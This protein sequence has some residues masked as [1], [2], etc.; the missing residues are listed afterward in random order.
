MKK[1]LVLLTGFVL[2][3]NVNMANAEE[4]EEIQ[5]K[6]LA[7]LLE[8]VRQGKVVNARINEQ[9]ER[10]FNADK[11]RQNQALSD[12]RRQQRNEEARSERLES[13]FEA[14]EQ[15]IAGLQE[16]L[17]KRLGS[18]RELF[19]VLQQVSG[20]TQGVFSGS[21]ISAQYPGREQWLGEFAQSMG[22]SSKLATI[23]EIERLWTEIQPE[24]T[25]SGK[26]VRFNTEV[27]AVDGQK[28]QREV[29]RIGAWNLVSNGEYV[30]YDIENDIVKELPR[31]PAGRFV[32][33]AASLEGSSS[34]FVPFGVDPTRGQLLALQV[35]IPTIEE[36]I[37]QGQTTGYVILALGGIALLLTLERL[38]RLGLMS[39]QV[40]R[41]IKNSDTPGNNP[42]G[43][44]L[45]V[46]HD[47][48]DVSADNLM[49][50][51][52]EQMLKE[53][54]KINRNIAFIKIISMVAPLLGLLG[55]VTGMIIT[56]QAITLFG[57]G[58]P[59]TMAG[60]ISQAL[61]TTVLGLVVAIPTVL[62][63]S[64]VHSRAQS[65]L[66]VLEEQSAGMIAEHV[67]GEKAA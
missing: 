51:L 62:L 45:A 38:V 20:D 17:S 27:T 34:G 41:Q 23:E 37:H 31:Q 63:H 3:L 43:R 9:R 42:L 55:T 44:I 11:S 7:E 29:V 58:D 2:A 10:D 46:Y 40:S 5:A 53:R 16:I 48:K 39:A 67:E 25:E 54:P 65:I 35:E 24:M 50:H 8:L 19:G 1:A 52:D 64:I 57:T 6:S 59:K 60:G 28:S 66:H 21:L 56:F 32:S 47:N 49:L 26:V 15:Q 36:R 30:S 14:N 22:R 12:A 4:A 13:Q 33:S 18:L 61:M